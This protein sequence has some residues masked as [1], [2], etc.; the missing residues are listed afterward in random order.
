[1]VYMIYVEAVNYVRRVWIS[2][3]M[4]LELI[5]SNEC[6]HGGT[7]IWFSVFAG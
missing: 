5:K 2:A 6:Q 3:K 4:R 7:G 1:M